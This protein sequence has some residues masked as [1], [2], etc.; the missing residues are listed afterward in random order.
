MPVVLDAQHFVALQAEG[1]QASV[2]LLLA[3]RGPQA[4][5]V[6][7]LVDEAAASQVK[8]EVVDGALVAVW[9]LRTSTQRCP[10]LNGGA[11]R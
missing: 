6:A 4:E 11:V 10:T 9:H 7:L 8:L 5:G 2:D 3:V 1:L